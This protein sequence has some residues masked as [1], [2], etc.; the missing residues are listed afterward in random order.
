MA[1]IDKVRFGVVPR[2]AAAEE[3]DVDPRD[4]APVTAGV[5]VWP[6][7]IVALMPKPLEVTVRFC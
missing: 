6:A 5:K 1:R 7:Q 3:V 4:S 2:A